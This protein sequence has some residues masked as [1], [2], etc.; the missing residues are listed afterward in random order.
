M[1]VWRSLTGGSPFTKLSVPSFLALP[2]PKID[3]IFSFVRL[4]SVAFK[5][6]LWVIK[7]KEGEDEDGKE[8]EEGEEVSRD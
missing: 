8:E 7:K 1:L 6:L 4:S 2:F 3:F 5:S